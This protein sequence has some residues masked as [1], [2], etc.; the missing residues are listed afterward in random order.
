M[1]SAFNYDSYSLWDTILLQPK[2]NG[3]ETQGILPADPEVSPYVYK[4]GYGLYGSAAAESKTVN[5][6]DF[7]FS[8][9]RDDIESHIRT[10]V[11]IREG[12]KLVLGKIRL[13]SFENADLFLVL[14]TKVY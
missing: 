1:K 11:T 14:T 7:M 13:M 8:I 6:A 4:V 10:D 3:G 5:L 2:G 9:K 12:Q